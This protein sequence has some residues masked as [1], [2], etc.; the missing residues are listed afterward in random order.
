MSR[1]LGRPIN[2]YHGIYHAEEF[3]TVVKVWTPVPDC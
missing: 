3:D 1:A 2:F